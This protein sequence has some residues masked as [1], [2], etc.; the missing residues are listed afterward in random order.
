MGGYDDLPWP[1]VLMLLIPYLL[2]FGGIGIL[3][4]IVGY[5]C[6]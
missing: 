6:F 2:L 3:I 1:L 4:L 5:L